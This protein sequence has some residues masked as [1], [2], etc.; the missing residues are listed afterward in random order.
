MRV[1]KAYLRAAKLQ[2]VQELKRVSMLNRDELCAELHRLCGFRV[3]DHTR[4]Q[5][6]HVAMYWLVE[7]A[8]PSSMVG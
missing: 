2:L 8:I 4:E 7:D 3:I 1:T 5:L 6:L